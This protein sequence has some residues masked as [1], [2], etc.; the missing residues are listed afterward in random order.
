MGKAKI[1]YGKGIYF[2]ENAEITYD[3]GSNLLKD[4]SKVQKEGF[5]SWKRP[6][7]STAG[8]LHRRK[9]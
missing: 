7:K 9:G 5:I 4:Q 8:D 6:Q 1:R 2:I 3:R